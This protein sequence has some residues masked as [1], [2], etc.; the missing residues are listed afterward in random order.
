MG[1]GLSR[2]GKLPP[3]TATNFDPSAE[4]ATADQM[5]VGVLIG[6]HVWAQVSST[7]ASRTP[8]AI[9]PDTKAFGFVTHLIFLISKATV[10]KAFTVVNSPCHPA[11]GKAK[12]GTRGGPPLQPYVNW[13]EELRDALA[14]AGR[15]RRRREDTLA[16]PAKHL[17]TWDTPPRP[18]PYKE[19]FS[20]RLC[21]PCVLSRPGNSLPICVHLS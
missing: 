1:R 4:Q 6:V 14:A 11:A 2:K 18:I 17:E 9:Q 7:A 21:V 20:S 15:S 19:F 5:L 8:P 12:S 3:A 13:R 10:L 16:I